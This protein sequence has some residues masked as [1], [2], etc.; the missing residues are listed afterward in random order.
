METIPYTYKLIFKPT[1][2]YY[3]GVRYAK[4][5]NPTD[6]WDKYFTSS[7]HIHKLIK[8][9]GLNSFIIKIT[10][11]FNDKNDA[12]THELNVLTRANA[13]K[14]GK[15]INKTICKAPPSHD[16]LIIIHHIELDF[17][18]FHSPNLPIP[19]GWI[20]GTNDKHKITQSNIRKGKPAHNKNKKCK[21]TGPCTKERKIAISESRKLTPKITCEYCG[22]Q[23]DG[24][25]FK[26][27][28]GDN[29]KSNPNI[30]QQKIKER[31]EI[32]KKSYL[33]QINKGNFNKFKG[34]IRE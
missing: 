29:C 11:T 34:K 18:T 5:C 16:G 30:D 1:G 12:I 4:G 24:G 20:K 10:K 22:K 25:N 15:F 27:F 8:E 28:H 17:E 3:Y 26:R 33:T 6:L 9:Y 14:N 21:L 23:C 13:H 19:I 2:Q 7:K 32:T 31:S